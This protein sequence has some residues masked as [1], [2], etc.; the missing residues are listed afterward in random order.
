M[1]NRDR[2]RNV[3]V[4]GLALSPDF[5]AEEVRLF[6]T[7]GWDS[8]GHMSL[9]VAIEDEFEVELSVHH[10]IALNTF[11]MAVRALQDLGVNV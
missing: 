7:P 3:F 1:T 2:L 4:G 9:V 5:D 11:E 8:M 10:I 6:E